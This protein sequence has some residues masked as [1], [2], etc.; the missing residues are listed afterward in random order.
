MFK[1]KASY[2]LLITH[3]KNLSLSEFSN[4]LNDALLNKNQDSFWKSWHSKFKAKSKS[5]VVGGETSSKNIAEAFANHFEG[6]YTGCGWS[7]EKDCENI[8]CHRMINYQ[9]DDTD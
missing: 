6:I 7:K 4:E 2:K 8:F 9:G 3:K 1:S 5:I